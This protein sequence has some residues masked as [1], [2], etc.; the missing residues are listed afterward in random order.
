MVF[1]FV[2][3]A[4]LLFKLPE[5]SHVILYL[6]AMLHNLGKNSDVKKNIIILVY[7][8]PVMAYH[9]NG[10]LR[11]KGLDSITQK[12]KYVFYGMMLFLLILNSGTTADFIY[13]Q[14]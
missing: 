7:S 12:Y 3:F 8:F 1:I 10:Y 11:E 9:F 4:W 13:F 14:F 5:F 2:T 6:Q